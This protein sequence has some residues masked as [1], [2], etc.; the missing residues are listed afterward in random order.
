MR[1]LQERLIL[2]AMLEK[3]QHSTEIAALAV[4]MLELVKVLDLLSL[5]KT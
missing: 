4:L 3:I 2:N 5:S 1:T